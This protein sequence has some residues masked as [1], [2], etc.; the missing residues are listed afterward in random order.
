MGKRKRSA[1]WN[2]LIVATVLLC[3]SVFVEHYKNWY[4]LDKGRLKVLSG[5]YYQKIPLAQMDSLA[6]VDRL[7]E[8]ERAH[9]FSWKAKEK[10]VF[11]D[12]ISGSR[13]HVFVD[14]LHQ[15]KIRMVHHDSLLLYLNLADSLET[16]KLFLELQNGM[17]AAKE[18]LSAPDP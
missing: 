14:D 11:M 13:V 3:L 9:G 5:I 10:G 7:P 6:L 4:S 16:Q 12:S 15:R 2:G 18:A 1:L 8:M 17:E